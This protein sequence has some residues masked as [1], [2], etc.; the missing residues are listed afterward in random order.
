MLHKKQK[1]MC[2]TKKYGPLEKNFT[3][4]AATNLNIDCL[5]TSR[6]KTQAWDHLVLPSAEAL[7]PPKWLKSRPCTL[8]VMSSGAWCR[9]GQTLEKS[10]C[11]SS[12]CEAL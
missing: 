8:T 4:V 10:F 3:C 6:N 5:I 1:K 12:L 7:R 9:K 2:H 11:F